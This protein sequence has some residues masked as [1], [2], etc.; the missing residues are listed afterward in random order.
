MKTIIFEI[1]AAVVSII[2]AFVVYS[3][4]IEYKIAI[5]VSFMVLAF[6]WI[7]WGALEIKVS[8]HHKRSQRLSWYNKMGMLESG[9]FVE[10]EHAIKYW[11]NLVNLK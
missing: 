1:L 9:Y 3:I 7:V 8:R 5:G 11:R 2:Y 6:C 4:A 10:P